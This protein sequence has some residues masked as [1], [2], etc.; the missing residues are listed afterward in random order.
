MLD[1]EYGESYADGEII[2]YFWEW[3]VK[4]WRIEFKQARVEEARQF[5][6][7]LRNKTRDI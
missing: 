4:E 2:I 6:I 5:F 7:E 1:D 3:S